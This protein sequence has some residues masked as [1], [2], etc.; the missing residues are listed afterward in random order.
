MSKITTEDCKQFILENCT[1]EN[2]ITHIDDWKRIKKYKNEEGLVERQFQHPQHGILTLVEKNGA[3]EVVNSEEKDN[4]HILPFKKFSAQ[5]LKEAKQLVEDYYENDTVPVASQP[6]YLAI[7]NMYS[8]CFLEDSNIDLPEVIEDINKG[9]DVH[10]L[11]TGLN[12]F[13]VNHYSSDYNCIHCENILKDFLPEFL[14]ET[15]EANFSIYSEYSMVYGEDRKDV[16]NTM[17]QIKLLEFIQDMTQRGFH[18]DKSQCAFGNLMKNYKEVAFDSN[19][20]KFK[21]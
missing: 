17:P 9:K 3:L 19:S 16:E 1:K 7:P 15:E 8:F 12:V 21:P 4:K 10:G 18:Y 13:F 14:E 2:M 6:G 20:K 5:E 11:V